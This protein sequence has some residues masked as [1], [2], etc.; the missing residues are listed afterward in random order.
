MSRSMVMIGGKEEVMVSG[1]CASCSLSSQGCK[2]RRNTRQCSASR[3]ACSMSRW[4]CEKPWA[5]VLCTTSRLWRMVRIGTELSWPLTDSNLNWRAFQN[6][7]KRVYICIRTS[8]WYSAFQRQRAFVAQ[9]QSTGLVNQGS[10][11]RSSSEAL[12]YSAFIFFSLAFFNF[13]TSFKLTSISSRGPANFPH[14]LLIAPLGSQC[15][16]I[17]TC[18]IHV[19]TAVSST[20]T[21]TECLSGLVRAVSA[22]ADIEGSGNTTFP[23]K[24]KEYMY[25]YTHVCTSPISTCLCTCC[26]Q[27]CPSSRH[28]SV[29]K[30]TEA[31][32]STRT[33]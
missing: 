21:T 10:G 31:R 7:R 33:V 8:K 22:R 9:W 28:L 32:A 20:W 4:A 29:G 24:K 27:G 15:S 11:V 19:T 23:Y 16:A 1:C 18:F 3:A 12:F 25:I 17:L 6:C 30:E 13:Y 5:Y 14:F 2:V 26:M